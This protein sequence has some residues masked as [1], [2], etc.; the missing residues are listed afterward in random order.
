MAISS[1]T[2]GGWTDLEMVPW[3]CSAFLL[4][5]ES[6]LD[7]ETQS[8]MSGEGFF[9][10]KKIFPVAEWIHGTEPLMATLN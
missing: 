2:Q 6:S 10:W 7:K 9:Y 4:Q 1:F 8:L 3:I 5:K